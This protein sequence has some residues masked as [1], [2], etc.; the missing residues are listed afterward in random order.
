MVSDNGK[1]F[2]SADKIIYSIL[3]H[4]DVKQ[5]SSNISLQWCFNLEKAL[6]WGGLFERMIKSMK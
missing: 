3:T 4:P 5:Y 6:W 1:A 2:K